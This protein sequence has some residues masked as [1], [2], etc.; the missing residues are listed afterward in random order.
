[1]RVLFI[2]TANS[3]RSQMAEAWARHLYPQDWE[4]CSAGLLIYRIT[5]KTR[6]T[7]AEVGL[8]MAG[9]KPK[10]FDVFDLDSFDRVV[11]LSDEANRYLPALKDPTR[12]LKN[13]IIDPMAATGT[14]EEVAAAFR[15]GRETIRDIVSSLLP[16]ENTPKDA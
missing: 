3:C 6:H 10:T 11:T 4:V 7:M 13:P 9:Q 1:M 5:E 15:E 14:P 12:H 16:S 8:D 2:C